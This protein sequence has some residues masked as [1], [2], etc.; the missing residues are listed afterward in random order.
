MRY[1]ETI[2]DMGY[3]GMNPVQ[4]GYEDCEPSHSFGPAVREYWL[5]HYVA[6]VNDDMAQAMKDGVCRVHTLQQIEENSR[7]I[8]NAALALFIGQ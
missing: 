7:A 6:S 5:L 2:M 1:L 3:G 8:E 4:L